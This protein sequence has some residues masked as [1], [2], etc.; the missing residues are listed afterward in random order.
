MAVLGRRDH[1]VNTECAPCHT[2]PGLH[3]TVDGPASLKPSSDRSVK[4]LFFSTWHSF[5]LNMFWPTTVHMNE[6]ATCGVCM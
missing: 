2:A 3:C 4:F 1:A 5:Y 6:K